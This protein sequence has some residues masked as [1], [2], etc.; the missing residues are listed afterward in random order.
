MSE[1]RLIADEWFLLLSSHCPDADHCGLLVRTSNRCRLA[2][3]HLEN[4]SESLQEL[5]DHGGEP[6]GWVASYFDHESQADAERAIGYKISFLNRMDNGEVVPCI[7]YIAVLPEY[8]EHDR[9]EHIE[10][11]MTEV[12]GDLRE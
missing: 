7:S 4:A 6:F 5:L 12:L 2:E 3:P 1:R 11:L 10:A 9:I 8:E